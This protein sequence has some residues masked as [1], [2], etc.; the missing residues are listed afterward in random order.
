MMDIQVVNVDQTTRKIFFE[1]R[2]RKL[3]GISKLLQVV[4]LSLLNVPGRDVL[5]PAKGGG[6]PELVGS[7]ISPKDSTEIFADL[8]QRI[9]K[10]E[11]EIIEDQIG[12]DDPPDEKLRE[13]QI[14]DIREG[15][16]I[17][18]IFVR[19]RIINQAGQASDIL[20]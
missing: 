6:L 19:I 15:E 18:E 14:L 10:T 16:Q 11:Q 20:V 1:V 4:V 12:I 2:P 9:K 17:D 8:A 7:N 5:D 3:T 13:L